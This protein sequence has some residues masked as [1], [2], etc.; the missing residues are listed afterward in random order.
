MK[1]GIILSDCEHALVVCRQTRHGLNAG[2]IDRVDG[3]GRL[4]GVVV[5]LLG[6]AELGAGGHKRNTLRG[7]QEGIDFLHL[8]LEV[9]VGARV[10]GGAVTLDDLVPHD[11]VIVGVG[12]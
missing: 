11:Q 3:V 6:S 4:V 12:I 10:I 5:A 7:E 8:L 1:R 9:L 2:P